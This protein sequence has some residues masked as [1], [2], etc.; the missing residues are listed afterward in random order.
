MKKLNVA[1]VGATGLVGSTMLKV[2]EEREFPVAQIYAFATARSA[3][4]TVMFHGAPCVVEELTETSFV[5]HDIDVA[6]LSAGG[7]TSKV[8]APLAAEAGV[9]VI[10]NSSQWR[11]VDGIPLVVP[12]VNPEV[13]KGYRGIIAN[14]NCST[15]QCMPILKTLRDR[16]GL[17]RI[18]Y[19]TYQAAAG[20]GMKGLHDLEEGTT[21]TFDYP[22][23]LN[24][25]PRIDEFMEDGSTKE[26]WKMVQETRKILGLPD[27]AV[28]A[29]CVRVPVDFGHGVAIN[30]ELQDD[31]DLETVR[32]D[33]EAQD[34]VIVKDDPKNHVYPIP[35][36]CKFN[37]MIY[38][39]RI[40]R[41]ASQPNTLNLWCVADNIRKGAATNSVQIAE[42]WLEYAD[43]SWFADREEA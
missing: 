35:Q 39:G 19:S 25:L 34:G 4:K 7:G 16:Y 3:G 17:K 5:D 21:T 28:T 27:L 18:V 36:D 10:D 14:P 26:E 1:V 38:V 12:E 2:L 41:D 43:E 40:R 6:L 29:T 22:L 30:A 23:P 31:F 20:A 9:T 8:Y 15:I 11:Q 13:I 37:D 32:A 42:K 24:V 33:L